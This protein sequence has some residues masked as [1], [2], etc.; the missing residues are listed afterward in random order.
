MSRNYSVHHAETRET[1]DTFAEVLPFV[2]DVPSVDD[3]PEA[4]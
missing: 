4:V 3:S 1:E 2:V